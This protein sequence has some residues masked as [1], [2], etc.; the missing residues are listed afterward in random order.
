M[1]RTWAENKLESGVIQIFGIANFLRLLM[2]G[3]TLE[4][5]VSQITPER[6]MEAIEAAGVRNGRNPLND[7]E[8]ACLA[9][10]ASAKLLEAANI[11]ETR[12]AMAGGGA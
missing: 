7:Q 2:G 3:A 1:S 9:R 11:L 8:L 10:S 12:S 6:A 4:E 5:C